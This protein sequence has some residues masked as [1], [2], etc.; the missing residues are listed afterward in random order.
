VTARADV[1]GIVKRKT[2]NCRKIFMHHFVIL[3]LLLLCSLRQLYLSITGWFIS[4]RTRKLNACTDSQILLQIVFTILLS[5]VL[6]LISRAYL[7]SPIFTS[8]VYM[9]YS[10]LSLHNDLFDGFNYIKYLIYC[11]SLSV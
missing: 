7:R 6:C 3:R 5:F 8:F 11:S 2:S 10:C 4:L 1:L 9:A